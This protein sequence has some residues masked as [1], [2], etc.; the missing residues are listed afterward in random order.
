MAGRAMNCW[1]LNR[2]GKRE[3]APRGAHTGGWLAWQRYTRWSSS[4]GNDQTATG[5]DERQKHLA[6]S[7]SSILLTS[8][9]NRRIMFYYIGKRIGRCGAVPATLAP[10]VKSNAVL[11]FMCGCMCGC[12]G[13]S[14]EW[15]CPTVFWLFGCRFDRNGFKLRC[16]KTMEWILNNVVLQIPILFVLL[17]PFCAEPM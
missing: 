5:S 13:A 11:L 6:E 10:I 12:V 7:L 17:L 1:R 16:M 2:W 15:I 8:F 4:V 3:K 14:V 9:E